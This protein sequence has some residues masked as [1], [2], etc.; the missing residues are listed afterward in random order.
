[1]API[2][3]GDEILW[4]IEESATLFIEPDTERA[5]TGRITFP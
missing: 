1:V 3:G 5:G 4:E 2:S